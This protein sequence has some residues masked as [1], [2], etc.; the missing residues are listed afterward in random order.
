MK[1]YYRRFATPTRPTLCKKRS[2]KFRHRGRYFAEFLE[3]MS[4][5]ICTQ[6]NLNLP[7]VTVISVNIAPEYTITLP[8]F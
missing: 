7:K 1:L 8:S 3:K 2:A 4:R 5:E 6:Y